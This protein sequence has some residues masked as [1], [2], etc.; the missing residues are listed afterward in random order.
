MRVLIG[1]EFSG[2]VRE[3]FEKKGHDA[4]SCDLLPSEKEKFVR[5]GGK[6]YD[7]PLEYLLNDG[8]NPPWDLLI[9]FPPCTHISSAGA[10]YWPEK[11][12]DGRQQIALD[13]VYKIWNST[14][15]KIAIEN[16]VGILSTVWKKPDQIINPY[17]FGTPERKKTC[18]WLKNLPKLIPTNQLPAPLAIGSCIKRNGRKYN[19][20]Y[21]QSKTPHERSRFWPS[22]AEAMAEQWG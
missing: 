10:V 21:H 12:K 6:H 15:K 7:C 19:Y 3:A 11:Q 9:A 13:F 17:D 8:Y 14:A 22:I 4:Y 2:I 16:P 20:Y 1:C 5:D 18:L